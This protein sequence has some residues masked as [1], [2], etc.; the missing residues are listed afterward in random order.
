[1]NQSTDALAEYVKT[2]LDG[3]RL[4]ARLDMVIVSLAVNVC[5]FALAAICLWVA[6]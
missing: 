4:L 6:S 5:M 3:E 2:R 1:M